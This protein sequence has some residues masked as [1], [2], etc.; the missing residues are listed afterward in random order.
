METLP[1]FPSKLALAEAGLA[2]R[3]QSAGRNGNPPRVSIKIGR[4]S[5]EGLATRLFAFGGQECTDESDGHTP[6]S[7]VGGY[8]FHGHEP[9]LEVAIA[10]GSTCCG[11]ERRFSARD[12]RFNPVSYTHL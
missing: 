1:G 3:S 6:P 7:L 4:E 10:E 8:Q 2:R 12:R 11:W 9:H 5:A